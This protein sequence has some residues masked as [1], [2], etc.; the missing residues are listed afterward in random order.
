MTVWDFMNITKKPID[1]CS[2]NMGGKMGEE[3]G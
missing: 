2:V 1:C 3:W